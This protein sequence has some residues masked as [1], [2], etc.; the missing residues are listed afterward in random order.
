MLFGTK[1]T[2]FYTYLK[3]IYTKIQNHF[4]KHNI[5]FH[6]ISGINIRTSFPNQNK[7]ANNLKSN[8]DFN[9]WLILKVF[10]PLDI[11]GEF[12]QD[13]KDSNQRGNPFYKRNNATK[14]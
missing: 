4:R 5:N 11:H 14:K 12:S 9:G 10:I 2:P 8:N 13:Y 1:L 6:Y 3:N 7:L